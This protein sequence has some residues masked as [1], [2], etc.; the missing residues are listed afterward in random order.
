MGVGRDPIFGTLGPRPLAMEGVAD[1]GTS[2]PY[3]CYHA[4]R[5]Y[6]MPK[7]VGLEGTP[8]LWNTGATFP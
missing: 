2:P 5:G 6:L 3:T 7:R 8:K 1:L 4:K